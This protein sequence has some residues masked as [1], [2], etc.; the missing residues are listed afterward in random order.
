[1]AREWCRPAS[2]VKVKFK[3][4]VDEVSVQL[5]KARYIFN[6]IS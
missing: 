4:K 3:G 5:G 6:G 1:V 2:Y